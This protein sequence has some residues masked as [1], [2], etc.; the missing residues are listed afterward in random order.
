M[1]LLAPMTEPL[2]LTVRNGERRCEAR[3]R[4]VIPACGRS[5]AT[6]RLSRRGKLHNLSR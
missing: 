4:A 2:G 3:T 6:V 1:A 5:T